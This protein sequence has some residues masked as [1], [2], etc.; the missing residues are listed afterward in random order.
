VN[1][2]NQKAG[3][4]P[5][6]A[7][8]AEIAAAWGQFPHREGFWLMLL[9]W[10]LLFQFLGNSTLGYIKSQSLIA[11]MVF[12]YGVSDNDTHGFFSPFLVPMLLWWKKDQ[13][14]PL[15]KSAWWPGLLLLLAALLLHVAGFLVQQA[16][17]SILAFYLGIYA[18]TG[19]AW[20]GAWLRAT[21]FPFCLLVFCVPVGT[22]VDAI[23]FPLR[24]VATTITTHLAHTVLGIQVIQKGTM[25]FD[26]GGNF[27]YDVAA[28][29]SGL[30]SLTALLLITIIY[31]FL[32]F[33]K[34]WQRG[35]IILLAGPAAIISN[36]V[37][38]LGIVVAA[39][40]FGQ[41]G[42]NYVHESTLL[43]FLPYLIGFSIVFGAGWLMER[44]QRPVVEKTKEAA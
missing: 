26:P 24:Q 28:A 30:R 22:A 29:C 21:F 23:T 14:L 35:F 2:T 6:S 41:E 4:A 10:V 40:L 5:L 32:F 33:K 38:L 42:G 20:G 11:W 1:E 18:L 39:Q 36:V 31:A 12:D 37:R 17:I 25:I 3:P 16:R 13:L 15:P 7:L 34:F 8:P 43:S 44:R 9:A 27:Q 19:I